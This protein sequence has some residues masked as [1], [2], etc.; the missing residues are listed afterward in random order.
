[1]IGPKIKFVK[2][3]LSGWH[4]FNFDIEEYFQTRISVVHQTRVYLLWRTD[5]Q[6]W[7]KPRLY[8]LYVQCI[9]I[10]LVGVSLY[11]WDVIHHTTTTFISNS[12]IWYFCFISISFVLFRMKEYENG[13]YNK[14]YK[15]FINLYLLFFYVPTTMDNWEL[16]FW[17]KC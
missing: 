13:A 15:I 16:I 2:S 3:C 1:M 4:F 11:I 6:I 5:H 9:C 14:H 10:Y 12:G 7:P 8:I 17:L